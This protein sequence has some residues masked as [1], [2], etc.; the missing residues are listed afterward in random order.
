MLFLLLMELYSL[1][2]T[3][4]Q[5]ILKSMKNKRVI[6]HIITSDNIPQWDPHEYK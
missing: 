5:H 4:R 3:S 6:N 2:F 1:T